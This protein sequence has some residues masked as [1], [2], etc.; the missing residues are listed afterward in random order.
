MARGQLNNEGYVL[1]SYV[2]QD[3]PPPIL[4]QRYVD[5][6]HKR[7]GDYSISLPAPVRLWPALLRLWEPLGKGRTDYQ[8][9][10][11]RRLQFAVSL[12]ETDPSGSRAFCETKGKNLFTAMLGISGIMLV[13]VVAIPF[14][15]IN[16]FLGR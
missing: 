1:L 10:L 11:V 13:E 9:E 14:R 3:T 12:A 2:L 6:V 5:A 15:L 8:R 7:I 4:V 16:T